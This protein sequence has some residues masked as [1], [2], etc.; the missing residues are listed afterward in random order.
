MDDWF[1]AYSAGF[2]DGEGYV[3]IRKQAPRPR[4][5][6]R[7]FHIEYGLAL[8]A[9]NINADVIHLLHERWGGEFTSIPS[10]RPEERDL[11]RWTVYTR[12]AVAF[13]RAI[14]PYVVVKKPQIDLALRFNDHVQECAAVRYQ[15]GVKGTVPYPPEVH[16]I[17]EE[18]FREMKR[19]NHRWVR[20]HGLPDG[21]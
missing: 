14:Y 20:T 18:F 1:T 4:K 7:G 19:L 5:T 11:Y 21:P 9:S 16:Q 12:K 13:M 3:A 8:R 15:A 10:R 17:R 6:E 2:F